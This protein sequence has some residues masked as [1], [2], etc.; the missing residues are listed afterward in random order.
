MNSF[1]SV[2][3][4]DLV[5]VAAQLDYEM[6]EGRPVPEEGLGDDKETVLVEL[7]SFLSGSDA[8]SKVA[9]IDGI[10]RRMGEWE[11]VKLVKGYTEYCSPERTGPE[12]C[13]QAVRVSQLARRIG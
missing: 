8:D 6:G 1:E 12:D 11:K 7:P 2:D 4:T 5:A 3:Y 9:E 13:N 10:G